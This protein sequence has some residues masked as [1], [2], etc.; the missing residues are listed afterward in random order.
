MKTLTSIFCV[1]ILGLIFLGSCKKEEEPIDYI[2]V[3][4]K[5]IQDYITANSLDAD[6][7]SSG[8]YYVIEK[9]GTGKRPG[10]YSDVKIKY[11]GY[12]SDGSVFDESTAGIRLNLSSVI[13]GWQEGV[14]FFKEG[15]EGILLIPSHLGYGNQATGSIPAHS[16]LIFEIKLEEVYQ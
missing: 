16:V 6:S 3:D 11:K 15:G 8:L 2:A 9:L 4:K 1:F 10:Q 7:T 5:I 13:S 12:L 14:P